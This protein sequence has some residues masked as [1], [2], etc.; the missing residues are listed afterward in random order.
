MMRETFLMDADL[1]SAGVK[2]GLVVVVKS[3]CA[4]GQTVGPVLADLAERSDLTVYTQDD[5]T[6][7][8]IADW[9]L[10]DTDLATS[11]RI[12]LETV[13]TVLRVA[14]GAEADRVGGWDRERW[15]EVAGVD[16]LGPDLPPFR[17][18]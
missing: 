15:E 6:F 1:R 12:D 3:S 17:P 4:T 14:D 10:D 2:D 8:A 9:V 7:P 5:P 11:W 18:G 13:P 16:G